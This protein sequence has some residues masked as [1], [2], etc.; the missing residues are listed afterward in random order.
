MSASM[1]L[2]SPAKSTTDS[3]PGGLLKVIRGDWAFKIDGA[4]DPF[5]ESIPSRTAQP[6]STFRHC[7]KRN[8]AQFDFRCTFAMSAI[9]PAARTHEKPAKSKSWFRCLA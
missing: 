4:P 8:A 6:T 5:P 9:I 1:Q 7:Y 2:E 3:D